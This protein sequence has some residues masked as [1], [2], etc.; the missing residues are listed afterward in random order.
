VDVFDAGDE[1]VGKEKN[2]LQGE[3]AVAEVEEVFQAGTEQV[4]YHGI[5]VTLGTEPANEW[6]T[7]TAGKG[8]VDTSLIFEL[9]VLGLDALKLDGDLLARDDIG[10]EVNITEG[11]ATDL[12]TDAIFITDAKILGGEVCQHDGLSLDGR[13]KS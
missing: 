8:L 13:G 6:D 5:V 11:A 9:R 12:T 1:L 2:G 4:E 3:L 7:D 10:A